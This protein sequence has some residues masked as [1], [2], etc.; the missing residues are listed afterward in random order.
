MDRIPSMRIAFAWLVF[1][2]DKSLFD[3]V[4]STEACSVVVVVVA[5]N[6]GPDAGTVAALGRKCSA[7]GEMCDD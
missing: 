4:V 7:T 5:S 1:P 3:D 6:V 2:G